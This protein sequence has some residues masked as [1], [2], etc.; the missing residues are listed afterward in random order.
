MGIG[1]QLPLSHVLGMRNITN[2]MWRDFLLL[3]ASKPV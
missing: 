2:A 1:R 3:V